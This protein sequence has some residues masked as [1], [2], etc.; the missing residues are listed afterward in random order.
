MVSHPAT[1]SAVAPLDLA[2]VPDHLDAVATAEWYRVGGLL[3]DL[4]ALSE[5]DRN[6]LAAYCV[7]YSR[8]SAAE[9]DV[10]K[11]GLIV[12]G[13]A[14]TPMQNPYLA[15]ANTAMRE[16]LAIG[17]QLGLATWPVAEPPAEDSQA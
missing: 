4:A 2:N 1:S 8:W 5:A 12:K 7:A 3:Q 13:T 15:I 10:R 9:A 17:K 11:L 16:M 6:T 14:G